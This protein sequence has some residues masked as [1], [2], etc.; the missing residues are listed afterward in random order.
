MS[1]TGNKSLP[2]WQHRWKIR[3]CNISMNLRISTVESKRY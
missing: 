2:G 1:P 3:S